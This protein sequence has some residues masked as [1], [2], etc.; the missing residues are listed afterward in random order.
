MKAPALAALLALIVAGSSPAMTEASPA[1]TEPARESVRLTVDGK[2]READVL[3]DGE[4]RAVLYYC[5]AS[6]QILWLDAAAQEA[7]AQAA[8]KYNE[9]FE[10]RALSRNKKASA[11]CYGTVRAYLE[12]GSSRKFMER[13][14]PAKIKLGYVF[15]G[16]S[17]YFCASV[18]CAQ[19]ER[20]PQN[21]ALAKS[22]SPRL[23]FTRA[24]LAALVKK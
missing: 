14:A 8:K 13:G 24:Q 10:R 18:P 5:Q 4:R 9:Q 17:P 22:E 15:I 3:F 11:S 12:W 1:M 16:K 20:S 23:L 19:S 6:Y 21:P 2:A 7:L